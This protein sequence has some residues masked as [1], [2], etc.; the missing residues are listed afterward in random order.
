M[1]E[2]ED[3]LQSFPMVEGEFVVMEVTTS[4]GDILGRGSVS[5]GGARLRSLGV[6]VVLG[7]T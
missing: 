3:T 7:M 2:V 5:I 6:L 1:L 4:G